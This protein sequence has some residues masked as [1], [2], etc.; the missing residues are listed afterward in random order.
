MFILDWNQQFPDAYDFLN[1][2]LTTSEIPVNNSTMYSNKQVDSWLATAAT[3]VNAE[4]RLQLYKDAT[5]QIMKDATWVPLYYGKATY[6]I[7]PWVHGY[8]IN[9]SEVDPLKYIWVD[10]TH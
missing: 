4:Q 7:Q 10:Q 8:Y 2:L 1:T 6:A 5:V 3:E 9:N